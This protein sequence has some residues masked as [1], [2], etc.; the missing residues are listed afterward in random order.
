MQGVEDF[1][2]KVKNHFP[3]PNLDLLESDD[4]EEVGEVEDEVRVEDIFSSA[5]EDR[6]T[7]EVVQLHLR[8]S[9]SFLIMQRS[10]NPPPHKG[11]LSL[12]FLYLSSSM[13]ELNVWSVPFVNLD[14]Y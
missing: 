7:K 8:S 13:F 6:V 2:E 10:M 9:S 11:G 5:R 1:K 3:D 12:F 4:E 14:V